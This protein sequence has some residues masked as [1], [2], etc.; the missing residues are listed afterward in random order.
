M[1]RRLPTLLSLTF[2]AT[3][4][5]FA[6]TSVLLAQP[7]PAKNDTPTTD[8][9]RTQEEN[10]KLFKRFQEEMLK[11]AQRWEKSDNPDERERAKTLRS[12]LKLIDDRGVENLYKDIVKGLGE[13]NPNEFNTL[14]GKDAKLVAALEEILQTLE[15]EDDAERLRR[16]IRELKEIIKEVQRI[17]REQE[18]LRARTENPRGDANKIAQDQNRITKDT[19]NI[20][21]KLG[22]KD[23]KNPNAGNPAGGGDDKAEPKPES[24]PGDSSPEMKPETPESKADGKPGDS[25][26]MPMGGMGGMEGGES[27]SSPMG[28]MPGGDDKPAPMGGMQGMQA[29]D[30][31]SGGD[32]KPM[33][34]GGPMEPK[35]GEQNQKPMAG[36]GKPQGSGKG[37]QKPSAGQQ[38]GDSKPMTQQG[39]MP[40]PGGQPSASKPSQGG[41]MSGGGGMTPPGGMQPRPNDQAQENIEQ[42]VPQQKGAEDDLKK[43]DRENASKKEDEAIKKLE[44]ALRELEKRLKQLREKELAKLLGNLEERVARMLKMQIEVYEATKRID[45]TVLKNKGQKTTAE[46]QKAQREADKELEII[47]EAEK[48]LKLMEG[49]GSAVVFAG[50]LAQVKGDMEAVQKRLNEARVERQTQIIEEDI[51]EQL[52]MMKEALKKA[53]QELENQQS[54]PSPPSDGKPPPPKLLD[55]IN[56]LKLIKSL[57][58]Q[59]N[60]RTIGYAKQDPGEQAKD[61][62]VQAELKQLADRQRVLQEML[63]KIATEA[64]R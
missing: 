27:K 44:E 31:K 16:E 17:K 63:H 32:S 1:F 58:E 42:A 47:V 57:Q 12:A 2:A 23:P 54:N 39:G 48:A 49:E 52:T 62:L 30:S 14:I 25:D 61:P 20:A 28:G 8:I 6:L 24:K 51:I 5:L 41:G 19:E 18:N 9:K 11:L 33:P 64:N 53:K 50:V 34:G 45:E 10:L 36:D 15:T 59:V 60:R 56:E 40:S 35:P 13:K 37:E 21:N 29:G 22:G 46:I 3:V 38:G 55:L 26:G 4:G 43:G 7:T